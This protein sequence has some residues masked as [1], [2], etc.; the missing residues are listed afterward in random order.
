[1]E[2]YI[3]DFL[4]LYDYPEE[5][6]SVLEDAYQKIVADGCREHAFHNLLQRYEQDMYYDFQVLQSQ[7]T[8]ISSDAGIHEYTGHLLLFICMSK[9]LKAFYCDA[10]IDEKVWFTTMYDLKWKMDECKCLYGIY[11]T[12]VAPWYRLLFQMRIF[13]F[14]KLQFETTTFGEYYEKNGIKLQ[15][16]SRILKIHIPRTGTKLDAES[17]KRSYTEA[18]D[19]YKNVLKYDTVVF[20]CRSWLLFPRNLEVL[21]PASNLYRF[22][23]DF[24]IFQQ[25][26][27]PDYSEV[28]RLFDAEYTAD[29]DQ[30]PQDTSL[31]RA[32]ADWIREGKPTGW[33]YGVL[34]R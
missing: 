18:A 24:D 7:M 32:Y 30:L 11:G 25:G 20:V 3:S 21:N 10:D 8:D 4:K 9:S 14:S 26:E 23:S 13:G 27:Y 17:L 5:S 12:F 1:M 31:R 22:I 33:G 2:K 19:F 34:V 15:P 16:D 28:W 6:I 29:V